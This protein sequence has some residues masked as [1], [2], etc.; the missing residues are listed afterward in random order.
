MSTAVATSSQVQ[1]NLQLQR[2]ARAVIG[3]MAAENGAQALAGPGL[4]ITTEHRDRAVAA[5]AH[6]SARTAWTPQQNV[7]SPAPES[8]NEHIIALRNNPASAQFFQEG[9]EV[10]VAD[11]SQVCA[12]QGHVLTDDATQRVAAVDPGDIRDIAALSLPL[13]EKSVLMA[14]FQPE[15]QSWV[16]SSANPNLRIAGHVQAEIQPGIHAFGFIVTTSTSF[17]QVARYN[18]RYLLRDGYHRAYGFL[19]RGIS[20]V[21]VFTRNY[22]SFAEM[23]LPSAGLSPQD[24]YLSDRPPVLTDYGNA[25]VSADVVLPVTQKVVVV[26]GLEISTLG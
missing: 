24:T 14:A 9:W 25:A 5:R 4:P 23:G 12:I 10:A 2:P 8:L 7:I 15:K 26:Q 3:W 19:A 11:L 17:I 22:E 13:A 16:F 1:G 6:V 21:P 20:R 18:G